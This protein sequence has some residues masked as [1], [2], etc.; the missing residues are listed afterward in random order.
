MLNC[1]NYIN[2]E[3]KAAGGRISNYNPADNRELVGT[4]PSSTPK[5][6]EEAVRAAGAAKEE[7]VKSGSIQRGSL[8]Y[9]AAE[10]LEERL[11]D[12]AAC[13][14]KE[15]GKTFAEAKGE[16]MRGVQIL[17][18]Y[19]AEGWKKDGDHL[20]SSD[21]GT[22][23]YTTR[24]P[25]GVVGII[26]PWNFPVAIP[27]WKMAPAFIYGNTV[28]MKPATEAAVT[29]AK[30]IEIFDDAGFP[31]GVVNYVTGKGS[32]VGQALA[33]HPEVDGI[34]FTGSDQTGKVIAQSCLEQGTKYQLEMGGKN[35][36]LVD[37]DADLER[38][39]DL[40]VSG[41]LKSAGQKCTA[42]SRVFIHEAVYDTFKKKLLEKVNSI[43]TGNGMKQN[44]WMGPVISDTQLDSILQYIEL[45]EKEGA[46]LIAGGRRIEDGAAAFGNFIEPTVFE[47]VTSEMTI[48]QEEI[49]GP[50]LALIKTASMEE[51]LQQ[52]NNTK[53]GLS[54]SYFT[55]DIEKALTFTEKIEAG[56][57]RVNGES[58][59]V[60][61]HAPF[62]GMKASSSYSREQ[63]EA[64]KEFYTSIKTVSITP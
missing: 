3:W 35:P 8:L 33:S 40:T 1:L 52:A 22:L 49:F 29:A 2:G 46:T 41:G 12:V 32:V 25:L 57:V 16:T 54:A 13:L 56:L 47:N 51:A 7:W 36:V 19:A 39:V 15:M 6:V 31:P 14:A 24:V 38:A 58:A 23:H 20:P 62:G 45:G 64:A 53:Y 26:S 48:A 30:L 28:V 11:D 37:E 34:S 21:P 60:E 43:Q 50:V 27:V 63:G 5:E 55:S 10:K 44:T 59:G 4:V 9:R 42:T 61:L 17:R 18:Y